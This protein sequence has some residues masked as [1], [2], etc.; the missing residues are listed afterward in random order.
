MLRSLLT[1]LS[2]AFILVACDKDKLE[3][4][5]SIKIKS[6]NGNVIPIGANLEL[7][8]EFADKEGDLNQGQLIYIRERLNLRPIADPNSNDKV[9]TVRTVLPDFPEKSRGEIKITIPYDF[10]TEDPFD[11]DTMQF[12]IAV[13][14]LGGNASDTITTENIIARQ[15]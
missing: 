7:L 2:L 3:T 5:P 4:K 6:I 11:N 13:Q 8:L 9:D 14:D 15:Q 10:L 1:I 12:R